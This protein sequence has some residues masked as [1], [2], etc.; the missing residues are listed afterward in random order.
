MLSGRTGL[1]TF[2][3]AFRGLVAVSQVTA[4]LQAIPPFWLVTIVHSLKSSVPEKDVP[5]HALG[6]CGRGR[7]GDP[8]THSCR[9]P[10]DIQRNRL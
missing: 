3:I 6:G 5:M 8:E 1:S 7:L 4:P 9:G 10:G 2:V